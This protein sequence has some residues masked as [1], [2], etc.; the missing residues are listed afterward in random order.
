MKKILLLLGIMLIFSCEKESCFI[1]DVEKPDM[2]I[3]SSGIYVRWEYVKQETFC[4]GIPESARLP[5]TIEE[6]FDNYEDRR[7]TNCIPY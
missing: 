1:C 5:R 4:D 2:V 7:Y 3:L 6:Y